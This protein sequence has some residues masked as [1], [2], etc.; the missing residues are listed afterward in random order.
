[1]TIRYMDFQ[2][3]DPA[4]LSGANTFRRGYKWA[5]LQI[6]QLILADVIGDREPDSD[7][8]PYGAQKPLIVEAIS[9]GH[10]GDL[11]NTHTDNNHAVGEEFA[12]GL[13]SING[14][15]IYPQRTVRYRE[16][17]D[18][19]PRHRRD[20]LHSV[21]TRIYEPELI[22]D[23][24]LID[25]SEAFTVVKFENDPEAA[26]IAFDLMSVEDLYGFEAD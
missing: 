18:P 2:K 9:V 5:D 3:I 13:R 25:L 1:M 7:A 12:A 8:L 16:N 15:F 17:T 20:Y 10:L 22:A 11:L 14:T 23:G 4:F 24:H 19:S 26:E 6:G 21:L